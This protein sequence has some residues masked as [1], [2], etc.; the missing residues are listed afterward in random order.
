MI[1]NLKI[2]LAITLLIGLLVLGIQNFSPGFKSR[3][4]TPESAISSIR[5]C[6]VSV[7]PIAK[8]IGVTG[9]VLPET[10]EE[11]V[12]PVDARIGRVLV[13][14]GQEVKRGQVMIELNEKELLQKITDARIKYLIAKLNLDELEAWESSPAY[15]TKKYQ[16]EN[17]QM[18]FEEGERTYE[19][20]VSLLEQ[21]AISKS[22]LLQ[23]ER[24][25]NRRRIA[26]ETAN[27][28]LAEE[29]KKGNNMA[30]EQARSELLVAESEL[31]E[32]KAVLQFKHISAPYDGFVSFD[33]GETT[34]Q[35]A[36]LLALSE[37]RQVSAGEFLLK[38]ENHDRFIVNARVSEFDATRLTPGQSCSIRVPALPD[39]M[40]SGRIVEIYPVFEKSS[41]TFF[42][43]RCLVDAS[44]VPL[45]SGLTAEINILLDQKINAL[46]IPLSALVTD[47]GRSQVFVVGEN[48]EVALSPV[49]I[50]IKNMNQVEIV[51]GLKQGQT[52]VCHIS[53]DLLKTV[54]DN[55][56]IP[57][58]HFPPGLPPT[59]VPQFTPGSGNPTM[60]GRTGP[61][62]PFPMPPKT[63]PG[64]RSSP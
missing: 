33:R 47:R 36:T 26:L 44:T 27:V 12:S 43:I 57:G 51:A 34:Q 52:I 20:N 45:K 35:D 19:E 10:V 61:V 6:T 16:V 50:G 64:A 41:R 8:Q 9:T 29:K 18:D 40:L 7:G 32:K 38:I 15:L 63:S 5:K 49:Q 11:V 1:K 42:E 28:S 58:G 48:G 59:V 60:G 25:L 46:V 3:S 4:E 39:T 22:D 54:Q 23:S 31:E 55:P 17:A 13:K 56:G 2:L 21:K 30:L 14:D 53:A 37:N 62:P 24:D